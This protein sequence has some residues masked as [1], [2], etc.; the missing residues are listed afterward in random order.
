M[1]KMFTLKNKWNC[2]SGFPMFMRH[3]LR[4]TAEKIVQKRA[5]HYW[6]GLWLVFVASCGYGLNASA[7]GQRA[8]IYQIDIPRQDVA[9][10]LTLLSEQTS[11]QVLFTHDLVKNRQANAVFGSFTLQ[12]AVNQLL[13]GTGISGGLSNKGVLTISLGELKVSNNQGEVSMNMKRNILASTVGL[14]MAGGVWAEEPG[15]DEELGWLLEEVIVTAT[16]RATSLNDTAISVA[17]IGGE[18]IAQQNLSG[19]DDYLRTLPGV[20]FLGQGLSR[21]A[22][23]IRGLGMS[24]QNE[25]A[26]SGP[27]T[28]LYFDEFSISAT[29]NLGG[30]PDLKMVDLE[31]VEVLRGPQGTLFGSSAL[32]GAVRNIPNAPKLNEFEGNIKTTYSNTGGFGSGNTKF[33]GVINI[34]LIEDVLAVRAVA[35]RH[36]DSGY[37]KNIA[38]TQLAAGGFNLT[39]ISTVDAAAKYNS[40][41]LYQDEDEVGETNFTGGRISGL[42]TPTEELSVTLQYITQEAQQDGFP[43]V[44]QNT[45]GYTQVALQYGNDVPADGDGFE[46]ELSITNLLVEYDLGW[47]SVLSSSTWIDDDSVWDYE[48]NV[49]FEA[50]ALQQLVRNYESFSQEFRLMSQQDGPLQYVLGVYYE[51]ID[52]NGSYDIYATSDLDQ[53]PISPTFFLPYGDDNPLLWDESDNRTTG[54]TA[55]YGELSYEFSEQWVLTAGVRRFDYDRTLRSVFDG[56]F[57]SA[58]RLDTLEESGNTFKTNLSY[59]PNEDALIYLQWAEGFR[60]GS[61]GFAPPESTC[62]VNGDGLLD[63]TTVPLKASIDSDSTE[64]F[65]LGVKLSSIHNR[66]QINA[67]IYQIDWQDIPLRVFGGALPGQEKTCFGSVASN[68]GEAELKGFEIETTYQ[69]TEGLR[70]S[71]GGAYN[72]AELSSVLTGVPFSVGD[73]LPGSPEYNI[74]FGLLYEFDIADNPS[75]FRSDYAYIGDYFNLPG[76]EGDKAGGYGQLNMSAGINVNQLSIELF[77]HNMTDNDAFTSIDEF[78][79]DTRAYR[80][81]PRTIGMNIAYQF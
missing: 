10:A 8:A 81:R 12:Q 11:V 70:V 15:S 76:E 35:Y 60:L 2:N 63:G 9:S 69:V 50:P 21:N 24:P 68:A 72:K 79:R 13:R 53:Y 59:K 32:A 26:T 37:V 4:K 17:A 7:E 44:Q 43:A 71:L 22:V 54:Q 16:R 66:L 27:T 23:V 62:D 29:G 56:T 20:N 19:M 34:P 45:G 31:R 73:R 74:N 49:F 14:I 80:L 39:D 57:G 18:D 75:Y 30:N 52:A 42:W 58:D 28:G 25:A 55:F 47:A 40:A 64:N 3:M 41:N 67:A 38:A 46:D 33:E 36:D 51:D 77:G 5:R 78:S 6:M 61:A 65:E 48:S 1:E